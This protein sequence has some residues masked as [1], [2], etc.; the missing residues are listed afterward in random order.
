MPYKPKPAGF[1][2]GGRR[3]DPRQM[4]KRDENELNINEQILQD[5]IARKA[6]RCEN[7]V[8]QYLKNA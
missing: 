3:P 7:G 1:N 4:R 8:D 2:P 6:L 5:R